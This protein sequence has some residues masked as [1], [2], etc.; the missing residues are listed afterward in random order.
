MPQA[1]RRWALVVSIALLASCAD[2]SLPES[3]IRLDDP[4]PALRLDSAGSVV[5]GG[6][7][8]AS[9]PEFRHRNGYLSLIVGDS[10]LAVLDGVEI[11]WFDQQ[12]RFLESVGRKGGGPQEFALLQAGCIVEKGS[13]LVDDVA[14]G[15]LALVVRGRGVVNVLSQSVGSLSPG[16]CPGDGSYVLTRTSRP[17]AGTR[18]VVLERHDLNGRGVS[19][20]T[21]IDVPPVLGSSKAVLLAT[22]HTWMTVGERHTDRLKWYRRPRGEVVTRRLVSDRARDPAAGFPEADGPGIENGHSSTGQLALFDQLVAGDH[23]T[24]WIRLTLLRKDRVHTWLHLSPSLGKVIARLDLPIEQDLRRR[25]ERPPPLP[26]AFV[27]NCVWMR[28]HDEDGGVRFVRYRLLG[29][30]PAREHSATR[31]RRADC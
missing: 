1:S 6:T 18:A 27:G 10:S 9:G 3:Q 24:V 4:M 30:T 28:E 12:G 13:V 17:S 8:P 19:A 11:H 31:S 21:Q 7:T 23:G 20:E 16:G 26:I 14:N 22:D 29:S 25:A 5:I 15:R 2:A